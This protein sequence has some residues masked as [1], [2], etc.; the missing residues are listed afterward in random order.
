MVSTATAGMWQTPPM[1]RTP[2]PPSSPRDRAIGL[3]ARREQS[4]RELQ[5]KLIAKGVTADAAKATVEQLAQARLQSDPRFAGMIVRKRSQDGYGP[6]RIRMELHSHGISTEQIE[7][8]LAAEA[9]DWQQLAQ[10]LYQR[11]VADQPATGFKERAKR[12]NWLAQ[13]GFPSELASRLA[14]LLGDD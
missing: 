7:L 12:A 3:L 9:V 10:R 1:V 6:L 8:A 14:H 5:R 4:Q 11:K 2:P 13:R